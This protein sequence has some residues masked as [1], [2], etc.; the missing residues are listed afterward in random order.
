[1]EG[2]GR[3]GKREGRVEGGGQ[4]KERGGRMKTDGIV[5]EGQIVW[6]AALSSSS[7]SF[8]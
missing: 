6:P 5:Q 3:G 8:M 7:K 4:E 1:M 2:R